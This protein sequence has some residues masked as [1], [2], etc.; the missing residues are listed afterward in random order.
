[1]QE[2]GIEQ[3]SRGAGVQRS[4]AEKTAERTAAARS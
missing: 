3:E 2:K 1:M 4:S